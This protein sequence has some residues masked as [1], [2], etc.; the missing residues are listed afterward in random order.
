MT[1]QALVIDDDLEFKDLLILRLKSIYPEL[2]V[3]HHPDLN[4]ARGFLKE[5][6]AIAFDLVVL[7]EHLPDGRGAEFLEE[8]WFEDL[9]VL[10][11]SSDTDPRIP[12]AT[13]HAGATYF[14]GK[15]QVSEALF[16][17]LVRGIVDRNK[18]Q[19][20][21]RI[22]QIQE[23]QM[24]T[25]R[26]LIGTLRHEI[27]N[28]LGAVLGAAYILRN[29]EATEQEQVDAA[30]L[31]E[32]SGKRIKHVLEKLVEAVDLESVEKAKHVVFQIPGDK[33]W[34]VDKK[35]E[36]KDDDTVD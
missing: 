2:I 34:D 19:R 33:Q 5:N 11:V 7:D 9:A 29:K 35:T 27:N 26:T 4:R 18:I 28:P 32:D 25:V 36:D 8:G 10:S 3:T 20:N 17:P 31:V 15:T 14:L 22:A 1:L 12:G 16:E 6:P 30:N 24:K 23:A 21:L 13:L